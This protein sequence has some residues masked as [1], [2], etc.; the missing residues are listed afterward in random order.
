MKSLY[1]KITKKEWYDLGGFANST[2]FRKANRHGV[3]LYY[4]DLDHPNAKA[5][6]NSGVD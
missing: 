6:S 5:L 4:V 2:L 1:K 3:W